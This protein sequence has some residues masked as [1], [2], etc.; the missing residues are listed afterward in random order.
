MG[1]ERLLKISVLTSRRPPGLLFH[2]ILSSAWHH[3]SHLSDFH[4]SK[5][6]AGKKRSGKSRVSYNWS[7][8]CHLTH[9][10]QE[11]LVTTP[12]HG[13][14][15]EWRKFRLLHVFNK[16]QNTMRITTFYKEFKKLL[17]S[18]MTTPWAGTIPV[19]SCQLALSHIISRLAEKYSPEP[20]T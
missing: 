6:Q 11:I 3:Q 10:R 17:N 15:K 2:S 14:W 20:H 16:T 9:K 8:H 12:L 19:G 1:C 13:H 7:S 4:N 18:S 5:S